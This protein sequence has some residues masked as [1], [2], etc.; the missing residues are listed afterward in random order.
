TTDQIYL[1]G[2]M[3]KR[4][5]EEQL[6]TPQ[7][8][9]KA[10]PEPNNIEHSALNIYQPHPS[11]YYY[12]ENTPQP[13]SSAYP[14]ETTQMGIKILNSAKPTFPTFRE[15]KIA[16]SSSS[17]NK[18]I[19]ILYFEV[20]KSNRQKNPHNLI[21][22]C[23]FQN[24]YEYLVPKNL[25]EVKELRIKKQLFILHW[26]TKQYP[27]IWLLIKD[28]GDSIN[29]RMR[30]I[31]D[32]L[33]DKTIYK[34][35][36]QIGYYPNI[37]MD[38]IQYAIKN[39]PYS[40]LSSIDEYP[41]SD[42]LYLKRN[43]TETIGDIWVKKRINPYYCLR[44][45][46]LMDE[47]N[48]KNAGANTDAELKL[49]KALNIILYIPEVYEDMR[50]ISNVNVT[51]L[52]D[53]ILNEKI[54]L[55]K[56]ITYSKKQISNMLNIVSYLIG[57]AQE[58][59]SLE[60]FS[61]S[62]IKNIL[63]GTEVYYVLNLAIK[64][65]HMFYLYS[66]DLACI[67]TN[68]IN[69]LHV[70]KD[71]KYMLLPSDKN[72]YL[73]GRS[74]I[75]DQ[76]YIEFNVEVRFEN[77]MAH[78]KLYCNT[79]DKKTTPLS[80]K[81]H[82]HVQ[83]VNNANQTIQM[84]H[85]PFST[86]QTSNTTCLA[87][88]H[89]IIDII[90]YI[91]KIFG[92]NPYLNEAQIANTNIYPFIFNRKTKK[93]EIIHY[94]S[95]YMTLTVQ[96][97]E[98]DGYNIVFYLI[99]ENI[100]QSNLMFIEF[101]CDDYKQINTDDKSTEPQSS[102]SSP[103]IPLFLSSLMMSIIT[104]S[105][106]DLGDVSKEYFARHYSYKNM[107]PIKVKYK[108][109]DYQRLK[110]SKN[111]KLLRNLKSYYN[112]FIIKNSNDIYEDIHC[113]CMNIREEWNGITCHL[114]WEFRIYKSVNEYTRYAFNNTDMDERPCSQK[115]EKSIIKSFMDTAI[116]TQPDSGMANYG[117]VFYKSS[118]G[119]YNSSPIVCYNMNKVLSTFSTKQEHAGD[120]SKYS[121]KLNQTKLLEI[122]NA[123][124]GII[125]IKNTDYRMSNYGLHT[126]I[127]DILTQPF[128]SYIE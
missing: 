67:D 96:Q 101:E 40:Y 89:R 71:R 100:M 41:I 32:F 55:S 66:P 87:Y 3:H 79:I 72:H 80:I 50:L 64:A 88:V 16:S 47:N 113:Y 107:V 84:I 38:L 1:E 125:Y 21:R 34:P 9:Q 127:L 27:N 103:R 110:N 31:V 83:F 57:V 33:T 69:T 112:N 10:I 81:E 76:E 74:S 108:D 53:L 91:N 116:N 56:D 11:T 105:D 106:L 30:V 43:H 45:L 128:D 23:N 8:I 48:Y 37:L 36:A 99:E 5:R 119:D 7:K 123:S 51:N 20:Y 60:N 17:N 26:Q 77:K 12:A 15:R 46:A 126:E 52:R 124:R 6:N 120:S 24:I 65:L 22:E 49:K 95:H 25:N 121:E 35:I 75:I 44:S 122:L 118:D 98:K 94:G 68:W 70:S 82:Y 29:E 39:G 90:L 114:K 42:N 104:F 62:S 92:N 63:I 14:H 109:Q 54:E 102:L 111:G 13:G 28:L 86:K 4:K 19:P 97:L 117:F 78:S 59:Q 115:L 85:I 61:F 73:L 58:N 2:G 93:W 18:N